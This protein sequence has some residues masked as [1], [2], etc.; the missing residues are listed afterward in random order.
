MLGG[1][2]YSFNEDGVQVEDNSIWSIC[3]VVNVLDITQQKFL[4]FNLNAWDDALTKHYTHTLWSYDKYE[5][6]CSTAFQLA[7]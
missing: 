7:L 5:K 6:K 2:V 1:L 4:M 3:I